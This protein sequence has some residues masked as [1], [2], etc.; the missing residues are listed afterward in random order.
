[1]CECAQSVYVD[2]LNTHGSPQRRCP[3]HARSGMF[4]DDDGALIGEYLWLAGQDASSCPAGW[5][6]LRKLREHHKLF[7]LGPHTHTQPMRRDF[8]LCERSGVSLWKDA[9]IV[10][11]TTSLSQGS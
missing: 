3:K 5:P 4:R 6:L 1:M 7:I 10:L 2:N 9:N 8:F 11:V